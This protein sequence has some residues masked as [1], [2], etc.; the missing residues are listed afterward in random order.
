MGLAHCRMV[1]LLL[2]RH[3]GGAKGISP[4]VTT[5]MTRDITTVSVGGALGKEK[6]H[7]LL[8]TA[9]QEKAFKN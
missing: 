5:T 2:G 7:P 3:P 9:S 8:T 6:S 4:L 1:R